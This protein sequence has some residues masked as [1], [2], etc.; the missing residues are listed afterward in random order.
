MQEKF[1]NE[2]NADAGDWTVTSTRRF[3]E[4]KPDVP[5]AFVKDHRTES[6]QSFSQQQTF[7]KF[8]YNRVL[9]SAKT[10]KPRPA[11]RRMSLETES[12]YS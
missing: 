12:R 10:E 4:I 8:Q 9:E 5:K 7:N 6:E 1:I 11:E 2:S 3:T